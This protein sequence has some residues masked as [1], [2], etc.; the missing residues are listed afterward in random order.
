MQK[1]HIRLAFARTPSEM[2]AVVCSN[3]VVCLTKLGFALGSHARVTY[4]RL[5]RRSDTTE[6]AKPTFLLFNIHMFQFSKPRTLWMLCKCHVPTEHHV[7]VART[8]P[9][10]PIKRVPHSMLSNKAHFGLHIVTRMTRVV[11]SLHVVRVK[12]INSKVYEMQFGTRKQFPWWEDQVSTFF[13]SLV[14]Y[15][16]AL[17]VLYA[18]CGCV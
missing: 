11:S 18:V 3:P 10:F 6:I 12:R 16:V 14:A 4:K 1:L 9:D 8:P 5:Y 13:Q 15:V 17:K 7:G 2:D